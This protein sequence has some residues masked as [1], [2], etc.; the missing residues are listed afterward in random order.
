MNPMN[1]F[2]IVGHY[3]NKFLYTCTCI[4]AMTGVMV[5]M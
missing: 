3:G 2:A 4:S 5:G 1:L